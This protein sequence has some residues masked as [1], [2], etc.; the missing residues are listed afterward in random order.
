MATRCAEGREELGEGH[1]ESACD[2][3]ERADAYVPFSPFDAPD[4]VPVQAGTFG[5]RLLRE[6]GPCPQ[7]T[8]PA[9]HRFR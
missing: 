3:P 1:I 5:Q 6:T 2:A 7:P 4:V 8:Y 9:S